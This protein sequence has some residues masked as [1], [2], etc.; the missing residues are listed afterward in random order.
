MRPDVSL[1]PLIPGSAAGKAQ[2]EYLS[3]PYEGSRAA[4]RPH[5]AQVRAQQHDPTTQP[6]S[7]LQRPSLRGGSGLDLPGFAQPGEG[8]FHFGT[9][10]LLWAPCS[11]G[12]IGIQAP[13]HGPH[14]CL[15]CGTAPG[16]ETSPAGALQLLLSLLS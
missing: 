12:A 6:T 1:S 2:E 5:P 10:L 14:S 9:A 3:L 13:T 15:T 7:T 11:A 16:P 8:M 4:S